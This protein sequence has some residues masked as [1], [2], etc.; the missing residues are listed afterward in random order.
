MTKA[1]RVT[2]PVVQI[3]TPDDWLVPLDTARA[4]FAKFPGP[5]CCWNFPAT[6][7]TLAWIG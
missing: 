4:L 5:K 2:V 1:P 3:H 7:T 6:T